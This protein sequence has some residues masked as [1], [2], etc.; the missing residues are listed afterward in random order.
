MVAA[1]ELVH[2]VPLVSVRSKSVPAAQLDALS[3]AERVLATEHEALRADVI[4]ERMLST[5]LWN[6]QGKT[7]SATVHARIATDIKNKA[8]ASRF[9]RTAPGTF[10]LRVWT[11]H[12]ATADLPPESTASPAALSFMDAAEHVLQRSDEH[13]PMHYGVITSQAI[14]G[15]LI[16][17]SGLTPERTMYAQLV[18]EIER[19]AKRADAQRF[20]RFPRGLFGL[21]SWGGADLQAQIG[22]HNRKNKK[23]LR[24]RLLAMEPPAFE[25]LVGDLLTKLGYQDVE[26]IG[27]HG[28]GGIDV[29]AVLVVGDVIRTR[30]AVQVKRWKHNVQAPVVQQVRGA[31]GAD[32]QG[33]IITTS[34]FS[35]GARE[36][37]A[38]S[39][40][41][42][43]GL[44]DGSKLVDLLV[45]HEIG[46]RRDHVDLL[47]LVEESQTADDRPQE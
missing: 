36:E 35:P 12:P 42:P 44:M 40:R 29:R 45:E 20:Q 30:M 6:S 7:P 10:G 17:T 5:G 33:L 16:V 24:A 32:D 9:V 34:D 22:A 26:V 1:T 47:W 31:I 41:A 21:A 28:D 13:Q 43:V 18:G 27:R 38:L 23:E 39:D 8:G 15:G 19:R 25:G 3:A 37:A 11:T 4:T 2:S 46:V 14:A